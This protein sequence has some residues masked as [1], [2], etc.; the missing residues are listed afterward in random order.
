MAVQT[1]PFEEFFFVWAETQDWKVPKLHTRI[2]DFLKTS[3]TWDNDVAVLQV[4]RGAAKSTIVGVFIVWMLTQD[5]TLRFLIQSADNETAKKVVADCASIINR[6]PFAQH[7]RSKHNVWQAHTFSVAGSNDARNHSVVAKG[8][9]SQVTSARADFVIF[10]DVE[11]P[12]NCSNAGMRAKLRKGIAEATHILVPGGKKLYIGTPHTYETLYEEVISQGSATLKIPLLTNTKGEFPT[13]TGRSAW[14]ERFDKEEIL[15]RQKHSQTKGDFLSQYQLVPTNSYDSRLDPERLK[16]YSEDAYI[17]QSQGVWRCKIGET[18][19]R[20]VAA[21]WDVSLAMDGRD[22]SV[23]AIIFQDEEGEY[24]IHKLKQLRGDIDEQCRQARNVCLELNVPIIHVETNG[25]GAFVPQK[26]KEHTRGTN[27]GVKGVH[28]SVSK[29]QKILEAFEVPLSGGFLHAHQSV[30]STKFPT[31]LRDFSMEHPQKH[32]D[33]VDAAAS[34]IRIKP[35][36]IGRGTINTGRQ[37]NRWDEL[38]ESVELERDR[39]Q[40]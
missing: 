18:L 8:V 21:F 7:L 36:M 2:I 1:I 33:W 16:I 13:M 15:K 11:V 38:G 22:D 26:L 25:V 24:Y 29:N 34:A 9:M 20:S 39:F 28:T 10:D 19:M 3:D 27:I 14:P 12:K 5:P 23:L 30:L 32:D 40:I 17:F 4:F 37:I 35:I 6:H 31:Q